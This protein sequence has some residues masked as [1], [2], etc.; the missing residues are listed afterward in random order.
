MWIEKVIH[1]KYNINGYNN[2]T[3]FVC[4]IFNNLRKRTKGTRRVYFLGVP[5][6]GNM[7][8][9]AIAL[10]MNELIN[11]Y[12]PEYEILNFKMSE[13]LG[14]I[15]PIMKD[16]NK[17]DLFILIGGGNMGIE[18][19]GNEEVRRLVIE[20]FPRNKIIIFPQTIDY[21]TSEEGKSELIKA[22]RIYS[23]HRD[24]HIFAR[25]NVSYKLI[26]TTFAKNKTYLVPDIVYSLKVDKTARKEYA[27]LCIRRDR[28]SSLTSTE[29]NDIEETV[30][31][32]SIIVK[33]DT[34]IPY[35]PTITSEEIRSKIVKRKIKEFSEAKFVVTDRLHGMIFSVITDTPCIVIG[36]YNHKLVSSY[37]TW[38]GN[39]NNVFFMKDI[40]E[41]NNIIEKL[42]IVINDKVDF[43]KEFLE[44]I[45]L[46]AL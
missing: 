30:S 3:E 12:Y 42:E 23:Q 21:G 2:P 38:L 17:R 5:E 18:Y 36:N 32:S 33:T 13:T 8:D 35:I 14:A 1:R 46:M 25:E 19:F 37:E 41:I 29:I 31:K 24:L 15:L 45:R 28:E 16:C 27:L 11:R 4:G 10:A 9:Q 6:H 40:K 44:L 22:E 20:A 39:N 34:V 7:G 43:E 26:K